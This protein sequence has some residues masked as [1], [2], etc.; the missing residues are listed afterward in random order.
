MHYLLI[1]LATL[2]GANEIAGDPWTRHT[3]DDTSRGADGA[4]L[5]DANGDA[6]PDIATPWEEGGVIRVYLHP[7]ADKAG[8]PWPN[9]TVGQP[10]A[11][12]DAVL[13]DLDGDG[14]ADV[15]SCTEGNDQTVY[16]HWAPG[17]EH[18]LDGAAWKMEAVPATHKASKWMFC[19]P[20]QIDGRYGI[21]LVLG[22]KGDRAQIGWLEAPEYPRDLGAW[23]YHK[24]LDV[25]WVMSVL[26]LDMN[27]DGFPDIAA[28]DRKSPK[29][30]GCLWLEH[31]G[32]DA[33]ANW[34]VHYLGAQRHEVMFID[35]PKPR[36]DTP[37]RVWAAVCRGPL[38]R[39]T[40]A[41]DGYEEDTL[42]M[43]PNAGSGKSVAR[44]DIDGD[45]D[46]DLA[47]TCE[48]ARGKHG[49]FWLEAFADGTAARTISGIEGTKFDLLTLHDLDGDGDLDALTCEERE[50]LGVIWY[51]NPAR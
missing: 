35:W 7:G 50:N 1:L 42:P 21:D 11:P 28:S 51:E 36:P 23:R 41:A 5:A 43:P 14:A 31:P 9:V 34:P 32:A 20:A 10:P 6:W 12:E 15:V 13:A 24:L 3:I 38:V 33:A 26:V 27:A 18:Y 48:H 47:V 29:T 25:S 39:L 8:Q 44:G 17:Q 19:V 37:H 30:R 45:G 2:S 22:S 16:V 4:R 46:A 40:Q 49:V